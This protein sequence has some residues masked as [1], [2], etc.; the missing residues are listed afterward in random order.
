[1][2]YINI[3]TPFNES[4]FLRQL[5]ANLAQQGFFFFENNFEDRLWDIVVVYEGLKMP[6]QIQCKKGGL[7]FISGEP[8][9]SRVYS[10]RF[11]KQFDCII[12]SHPKISH[13]NN[14]LSQQCLP[15]WYGYNSND[16]TYSL[17]FEDIV[18]MKPL[19]KSKS[20]SIISS[21]KRMMPGHGKR[22][23]FI[24]AL[25]SNFGSEIDFYG[26]G[27]NPINDKKEALSDYRFTISIENSSINDY[28]TEKIAD[29]FIAYTVPIYHGCKNIA[30]YFPE[31]SYIGIN[32]NDTT[33]ALSQIEHILNN[34][35]RIYADC[36][37]SLL[38]AREK[39]LF[40]YNLF[41]VIVSFW[42]NKSLLDEVKVEIFP[43]ENYSDYKFKMIKL[44]AIRG[45]YK[46]YRNL[47]FV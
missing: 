41:E 43:T 29:P 45:M 7:I 47:F 22:M 15:W 13:R 11:L 8:P 38:V 5:P 9:M 18:S 30:N 44:R 28:W 39:I 20:I 19:Q 2:V 36:L 35:D 42:R 32:I 33:G 4:L 1:M 16:C 3:L 14:I 27:I 25:Q 23:K 21:N 12:S 24:D 31:K 6:T 40:E 26:K 17:D 37:N 34:S 10:S 46:C